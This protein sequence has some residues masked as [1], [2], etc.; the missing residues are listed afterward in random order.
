VFDLLFLLSSSGMSAW[1][2]SKNLWISLSTPSERDWRVGGGGGISD[3]AAAVVGLCRAG[4][5]GAAAAA[6]AAFLSAE[7]P[8]QNQPIVVSVRN[9]VDYHRR[10]DVL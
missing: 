5:G 3:A 2:M 10:D 1:I 6:A 8:C 9:V 4:G 7:S